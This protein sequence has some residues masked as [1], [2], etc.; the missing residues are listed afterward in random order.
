MHKLDTLVSQLGYMISFVRSSLWLLEG[1][2]ISGELGCVPRESWLCPS[3]LAPRN[4]PR[5]ELYRGHTES[6]GVYTRVYCCVH[7]GILV[8]THVYTYPS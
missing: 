2:P 5:S 7:V 8:C 6:E 3:S 1:F 4:S